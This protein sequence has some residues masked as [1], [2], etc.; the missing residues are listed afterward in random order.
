MCARKRKNA[1]HRVRFLFGGSGVIITVCF[2]MSFFVQIDQ[3][4]LYKSISY[5]VRLGFGAYQNAVLS[6]AG[7]ELL[8]SPRL[9]ADFERWGFECS[10][11]A[12]GS[13]DNSLRP[14]A[15]C[16]RI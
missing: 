13:A 1:P 7:Q 8:R 2:Y 5:V 10:F 9:S 15:V 6:C 3:I 14:K 11:S 4:F 16:L 12:I